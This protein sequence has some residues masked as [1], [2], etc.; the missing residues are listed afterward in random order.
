MNKYFAI[1]PDGSKVTR[2]TKRTYTHAV[3]VRRAHQP[4][5]NHI[6]NL[7]KLEGKG[8]RSSFQYYVDRIEAHEAGRDYF[9]RSNG[10]KA[11][12]LTPAEVEKAA[13]V[14]DAGFD[15]YVA[16]RRKEL[17]D[18][19]TKMLD[20]GDFDSYS[21]IGWCGRPDLAQKLASK[22]AG[23]SRWA[24]VKIVEAQLMSR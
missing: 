5:I 11:D 6:E 1:C 17:M 16:A 18:R 7:E 2:N 22:E 20:A 8:M 23:D 15:G 19:Y 9:F 24:E 4:I 3:V 13:A 12:P 14:R 21:A 10:C